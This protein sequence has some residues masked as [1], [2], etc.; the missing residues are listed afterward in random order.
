MAEEEEKMNWIFQDYLP[1]GGAVLLAAKPK[2]GKTTLVYH[3]LA[4]LAQGHR[5]L[6]RDTIPTAVLILAVEEHRRDVKN[7]LRSLG[8]LDWRTSISNLAGLTGPILH[9]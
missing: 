3:L 8:V 1:V 2:T 7:R 6:E 4:A 9:Q 5:F